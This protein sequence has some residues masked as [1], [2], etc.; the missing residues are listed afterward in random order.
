MKIGGNPLILL[1]SPCL[2][3]RAQNFQMGLWQQIQYTPTTAISGRWGHAGAFSSTTNEYLV[4]SG[5]DGTTEFND[6]HSINPTSLQYR[7]LASNTL[8]GGRYLTTS[9]FDANSNMYVHGG[10]N[11]GKF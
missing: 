7:Q 6:F 4:V 2:L 5:R 3:S 9:A 1:L 10:R 8:L 11:L